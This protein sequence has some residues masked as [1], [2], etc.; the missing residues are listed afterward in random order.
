MA[1]PENLEWI[2]CKR[3]HAYTKNEAQYKAS[4]SSKFDGAVVLAYKCQFKKNHPK[5]KGYHIGHA[6]LLTRMKL[7]KEK[8]EKIKKQK[9]KKIAQKGGDTS[10]PSVP[11]GHSKNNSISKVG[12]DNG[13]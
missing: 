4:K 3:K 10:Q 6:N 2:M 7:V 13:G 11:A 5:G 9:A 12:V 1:K 8:I